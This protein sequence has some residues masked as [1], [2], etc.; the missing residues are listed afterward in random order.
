MATRDPMQPALAAFATFVL[1]LLAVAIG[2]R[3]YMKELQALRVQVHMQDSQVQAMRR[4][5]ARLQQRAAILADSAKACNRGREADRRWR[6]S[7]A[8][9]LSQLT[10]GTVPTKRRPLSQER[11]K[12]L[13]ARHAKLKEKRKVAA[14]AR[15]ELKAPVAN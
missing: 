13:R 7:P 10:N 3:P 6:A 15:K 4:S 14:A 9:L 12:A 1:T 5:D 2:A 8:V 11:L